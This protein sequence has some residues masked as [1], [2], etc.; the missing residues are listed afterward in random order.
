MEPLPSYTREQRRSRWAEIVCRNCQDD[1]VFRLSDA[2]RTHNWT[3]T[4]R[5]SLPNFGRWF[6]FA[7]KATAVLKT[8]LHR[9]S[10]GLSRFPTLAIRSF[11]WTS[12]RS[13]FCTVHMEGKQPWQS[14][15]DI[16]GTPI[17]RPS[18]GCRPVSIP[19]INSVKIAI[20]FTYYQA[21]RGRKIMPQRDRATTRIDRARL[22]FGPARPR[23]LPR[24]ST[25][26]RHERG[27]NDRGDA[28]YD[29]HE[30]D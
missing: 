24:S 2:Q 25:W 29:D 13:A 27:P 16:L 1:G 7:R 9:H 18:V 14:W 30:P 22:W 21:S 5:P 17:A 15:S 6:I 28:R 20:E 10:R 8:R 4:S 26:L 11:G 12:T 23:N 3:L 19:P